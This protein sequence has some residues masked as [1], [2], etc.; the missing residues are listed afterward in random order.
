VKFFT[1]DDEIK[2][3]VMRHRC[4]GRKMAFAKKQ[5]RMCLLLCLQCF[6]ARGEISM[7]DQTLR[8]GGAIVA[9]EG[10]SMALIGSPGDFL[11]TS[12]IFLSCRCSSF[13]DVRN[14]PL[15]VD[16]AKKSFAK[17]SLGIPLNK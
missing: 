11:A 14:F 15:P 6:H 8:A 3:T 4:G 1:V 2:S 10:K 7:S 9:A 13:Y 12:E 5:G 17:S 16:C